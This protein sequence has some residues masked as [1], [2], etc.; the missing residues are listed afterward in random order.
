M[1]SFDISMLR[2]PAAPAAFYFLAA[3][4]AL[5]FAFFMQYAEG[6]AP[7]HLCLLQ[8]WPYAAIMAAACAAFV[9]SGRSDRTA[10]ILVGMCALTCLGESGLAFYHAGVERHWWKSAFEACT[11]SFDPGRDLMEQIENTPA[12]R[13][14]EIPWSFLGLSMA[15]WNAVLALT[16]GLPGAAW[17]LMRRKKP[18]SSGGD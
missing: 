12:A 1:K 7:C 6:L 15:G 16:L 5:S 17:L 9:L 13:C 2:S 4:L 14:D 10:A 3:T 18:Q 8:R 11:F